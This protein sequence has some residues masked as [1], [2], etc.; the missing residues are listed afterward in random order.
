MHRTTIKTI[1]SKKIGLGHLNAMIFLTNQFP[2][3]LTTF[4]FII[5]NEIDA[6]KYLKQ[7][8]KKFFIDKNFKMNDHLIDQNCDVAIYYFPL[9]QFFIKKKKHF[10]TIFISNSLKK[11]KSNADVVILGPDKQVDYKYKKNFYTGPKYAIFEYSNFKY[12]HKKN[13]KNCLVCLGGTD[14]NNNIIKI[15]KALEY[16]NLKVNYSFFL[17]SNMMSKDISLFIKQNN[18]KKFKFIFNKKSLSSYLPSFHFGIISGGNILYQMCS[19]HIPTFVL[20][21]SKEE[22]LIAKSLQKKKCTIVSQS[23]FEN[24]DQTTFCMQL[25]KYINQNNKRKI[26]KQSC[27]RYFGKKNLSE[28]YKLIV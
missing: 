16:L 25:I 4:T 5:N 17:R 3:N 1:Y 14:K 12:N 22:M 10:K 2:K 20:P 18:N 19:S 9:D 15:I 23:N 28:V 27:K 8:K 21:Q 6:I 13:V 11:I 26:V 7:H 24:W